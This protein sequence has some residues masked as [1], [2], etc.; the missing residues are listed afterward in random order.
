M[1][2]FLEL[3]LGLK[4]NT[5]NFLLLLGKKS[6]VLTTWKLLELLDVLTYTMA[7]K[8]SPSATRAFPSKFCPMSPKEIFSC[9]H[10]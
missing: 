7:S 8:R 2:T 3:T 6:Q 10:I 4:L 9:D 5:E 1:S